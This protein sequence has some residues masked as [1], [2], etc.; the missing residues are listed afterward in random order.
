MNLNNLCPHSDSRRTVV[1]PTPRMA[2][3][4]LSTRI[5]KSHLSAVLLWGQLT[6]VPHQ[7]LFP[8]HAEKWFY[9]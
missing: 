3:F 6:N 7:S 5:P 1:R 9:C 2:T 4:E 8:A